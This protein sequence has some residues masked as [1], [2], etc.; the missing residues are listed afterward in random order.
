MPLS[1]QGVLPAG[2]NLGTINLFERVDMPLAA[3]DASF[4]LYLLDCQVLS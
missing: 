2:I 1:G 3:T 4:E